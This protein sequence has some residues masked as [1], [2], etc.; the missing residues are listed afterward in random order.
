MGNV[1][2]WS[3]GDPAERHLKHVVKQLEDEYPWAR[4]QW[5]R[6]QV[7]AVDGDLE[8]ARIAIEQKIGGARPFVEAHV[9]DVYGKGGDI[10]HG[11]VIER[12]KAYRGSEGAAKRSSRASHAQQADAGPDMQLVPPSMPLPGTWPAAGT[13]D[14]SERVITTLFN[15]NGSGEASHRWHSKSPNGLVSL[16]YTCRDLCGAS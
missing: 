11:P 15:W 6:K 2:S 10:S 8:Q 3:A 9:S 16:E 4:K 5:L 7:R 1:C 12:G 14:P 13:P